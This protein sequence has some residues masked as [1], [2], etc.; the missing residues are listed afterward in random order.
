MENVEDVRPF[1]REGYKLAIKKCYGHVQV[2]KE[3]VEEISERPHTATVNKVIQKLRMLRE[4][5]LNERQ[6][7]GQ[8]MLS[9]TAIL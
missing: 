1:W 7:L 2:A 5:Q 8:K 9:A 4:D 3:V 6:Q